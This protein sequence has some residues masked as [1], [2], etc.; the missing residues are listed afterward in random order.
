MLTQLHFN[1]GEI[2]FTRVY[3]VLLPLVPGAVLVGALG[4]AHSGHWLL[5]SESESLARAALW[6]LA[7]YVVGLLLFGSSV[8]V[9]TI[10]SGLAIGIV[11]RFTKP[12]RNNLAL[13]SGYRLAQRRVQIPRT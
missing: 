8:I 6:V 11:F 9:T 5:Q 10:V 1:L 13:S 2:G 3:Q 7:A 4:A 12:R